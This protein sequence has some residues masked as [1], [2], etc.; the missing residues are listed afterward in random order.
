MRRRLVAH[1][2]RR[3]Y[4]RDRR[5]GRAFLSVP[6]E[7]FLPDELSKAG[8]PGVYRDDAIVTR[9]D[10]A[11]RAPTSSSSQ[12]AI[13]AV[14][15]EMLDVQ[16][17]H[18]VLEIGAGTGYNAAILSQL[19]GPE[20]MVVTVDL[21]ADVAAAAAAA[22]RTVRWTAHVVVTDGTRGMP[23]MAPRS[24]GGGSAGDGRPGGGLGGGDGRPGGGLGGGAVGDSRDGVGGRGDLAGFGHGGSG[25]DGLGVGGS[26]VGGS[27]VGGSGV[28]GSAGGVD[29][30]VV[31]ASSDI[32][33][34]PW[35]E[36]L[37]PD[38]RLVVPLR[39]SDAADRAHA[40]TAFVKV[41]GGFD[42]VTVT[43]G[44]FM[45]L[46]RPPAVVEAEAMEAAAAEARAAATSGPALTQVWPPQ[47]PAPAPATR[48]QE[49][50]RGPWVDV[51]RDDVSRLRIIVR[52]GAARPPTR[53]AVRRGD[54]W[55]GI[56]KLLG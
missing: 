12:P 14:M 7:V 46:R 13:M 54:H 18:R 31:T 11:T 39:L 26:G 21:D 48:Q 53:W 55:I 19:A 4:L 30:L 29:R 28:G 50:R 6:R 17:G 42:S 27:G 22:L 5:I 45:P 9:R 10:P 2:R 33:P 3:G 15:L 43:S 36:Q 52:Y 34:R 20:G 24:S 16:P 49:L 51:T 41:D 37:A 32:V 1:L 56:D 23:G 44:G 38:G 47:A 40:V 25:G 35:F 8:L